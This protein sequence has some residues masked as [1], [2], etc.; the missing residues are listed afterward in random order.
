MT[1]KFVVTSPSMTPQTL[2]YDNYFRFDFSCNFNEITI[3]FASI[4]RCILRSWEKFFSL[5]NI[6]PS[7]GQIIYKELNENDKIKAEKKAREYAQ[8]KEREQ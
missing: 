1:E 4:L 7:V 6:T 5:R 3:V 2:D 8:F